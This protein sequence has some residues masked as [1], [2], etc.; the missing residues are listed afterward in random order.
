MTRTRV[1]TTRIALVMFG[2]AQDIGLGLKQSVQGLLYRF[3]HYA[4]DMR[5]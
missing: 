3:P 5:A 2:P 1:E 4:V